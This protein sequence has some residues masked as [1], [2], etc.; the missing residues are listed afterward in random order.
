MTCIGWLAVA[1]GRA[2]LL[3]APHLLRV[4]KRIK[5]WIL[6]RRP[7]DQRERDQ[8]R[9]GCPRSRTTAHR[10]PTSG[11]SAA[12]CAGQLPRSLHMAPYQSVSSGPVAPLSE[13]DLGDQPR[14]RTADRKGGRAVTLRS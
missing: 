4:S 13:P 10:S 1:A 3:F 9:M 11:T 2:R 6:A 12:S 7:V 8:V 14:E 5:E